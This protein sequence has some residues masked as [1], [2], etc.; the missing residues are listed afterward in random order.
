MNEETIND[1]W[2]LS[3]KILDQNF[4]NSDDLAVLLKVHTKFI[5]HDFLE[6]QISATQLEKKRAIEDKNNAQT[7]NQFFFNDRIKLINDKLKKENML[8]H[9]IECSFRY[10]LLKDFIKEN[11][12]D[13]ILNKFYEHIKTRS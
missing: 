11:Y 1:F 7:R 9:N 8:R 2:E 10:D 5:V 12:D 3:K 6:L 4:V 13:E